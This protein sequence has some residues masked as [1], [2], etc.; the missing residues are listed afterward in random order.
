MGKKLQYLKNK[1]I[2]KVVEWNELYTG[3]STGCN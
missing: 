1:L 2:L 3:E